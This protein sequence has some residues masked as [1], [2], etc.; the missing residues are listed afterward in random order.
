MSS[1]RASCERG[2]TCFFE[3]MTRDISPQAPK[4]FDIGLLI[5]TPVH[6]PRNIV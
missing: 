1:V 5:H 2:N 3:A 4:T 6:N